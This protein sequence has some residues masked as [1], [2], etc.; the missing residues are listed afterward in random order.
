MILQQGFCDFLSHEDT[1]EDDLKIFVS[2]VESQ[3]CLYHIYVHIYLHK[4]CP[5]LSLGLFSLVGGSCLFSEHFLGRATVLDLW[6]SAAAEAHGAA[7]PP[8]LLLTVRVEEC[9]C[10]PSGVCL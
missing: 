10:R 3:L 6:P 5:C 7:S 9:R 8:V 4:V 2:P 1:S